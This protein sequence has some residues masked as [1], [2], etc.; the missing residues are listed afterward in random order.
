MQECI[1][2][3]FCRTIHENIRI[4]VPKLHSRQNTFMYYSDEF[5]NMFELI[6]HCV[7]LK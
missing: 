7:V 3:E 4:K 1:F 5:K 6:F 2:I